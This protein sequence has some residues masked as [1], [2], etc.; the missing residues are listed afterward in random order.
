MIDIGRPLS[1][2]PQCRVAIAS[3]ESDRGKPLDRIRIAFG[4]Y[5][6]KIALSTST[7]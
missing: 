2:S 3:S 6:I 1:I 7:P 4:K 5:G